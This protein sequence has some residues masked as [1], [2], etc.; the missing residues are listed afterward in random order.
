MSDINV[1]TKIMSGFLN[2]I[3]AIAPDG[4]NTNYPRKSG[5]Q[6]PFGIFFG[7][8]PPQATAGIYIHNHIE[9][10]KEI[11]F[12]A[13]ILHEDRSFY[14]I[15]LSIGQICQIHIF[16][17]LFVAFLLFEKNIKI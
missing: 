7:Q 16:L 9:Y 3:P 13:P 2:E 14:I 1:N 12:A 6:L 4:I 5:D 8:Q 10:E 15:L 17:S 11:I